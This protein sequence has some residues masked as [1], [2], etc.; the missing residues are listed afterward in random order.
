MTRR[1]EAL[2]WIAL[3]AVYFLW[4]STY[5][6]I[7]VAVATIPPFL[8]TG[9]RYALAG[10]LLFAL[11]WFFAKKKPALPNRA[12]LLRIAVIGI[13][14][15]AVGNGL[16]CV[17]ETRVESGTAALLIASSPIF[18]VVVD[19]IRARKA[20]SALAV[21]GIVLG[22]IGIAFLVGRSSLH[23]DLLMAG[24]ILFSSFAWSVGSVYARDTPH[25]ALTAPL[26]MTIGGGVSILAGLAFGET[27]RLHVG[28]ITSESLW[29][30][31][32]LVF[33]GAIVG[34]SAFAYT[35]R[36]L[37]TATVAT[38]GYVNPVVA[39]ILGAI[40]LGEPVTWR[41]LAG[42]AAVVGS[43]ALILLGSRRTATAL[44]A[45]AS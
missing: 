38:Y 37:P 5:L 6:G 26:E 1:T 36:R 43:V 9:S 33:G 32:W 19:A 16:L 39:V 11:Q 29:G 42:G 24:L 4:G 27:S 7:R 17:A 15:L 3:V 20:P 23:T 44:D 8:M 35:V 34:Y 12:Q 25:H 14:L 31:L 40:V 30:M 45:P 22:S 28:A 41:I 10:V 21:A 2:P 18:M 13:L